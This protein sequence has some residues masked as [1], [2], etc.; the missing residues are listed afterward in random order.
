MG[1]C[2]G[3][4]P[5]S[6]RP[7]RRTVMASTSLVADPSAGTRRDGRTLAFAWLVTLVLSSL[8]AIVAAEAAGVRSAAAHWGTLAAAAPLAAVA[9]TWRPARPLRRYLLVAL[10]VFCVG[11]LLPPLLAGSAGTGGPGPPR[12]LRTKA[13]FVPGRAVW[14]R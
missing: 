12:A 11:Y 5:H 14:M 10:V 13:V 4:P 1:S 9:W 8:P 7:P 2:G 6:P 3:R